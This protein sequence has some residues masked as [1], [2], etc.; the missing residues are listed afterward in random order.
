M[1]DQWYYR[2]FGHDF[3]PVDFEELKLLAQQGALSSSDEVRASQSSEWVSASSVGELN[4][5]AES[6]EGVATAVMPAPTVTTTTGAD[7][8]YY[9]FHG[10]EMGPLGFD[11]LI[12]FTEQGQLSA[13]D[14]VKLGANGKWRRV[15]SI[16]RLVAVLP[17]MAIETQIPEKKAPAPP[18]ARA[19][20][21]LSPPEPVQQP[22][23]VSAPPPAPLPANDPLTA[24]AVAAAKAAAAVAAAHVELGH[25]Q[26][27]YATADKN[28][29]GMI[30]WAMAP[31]VDPSW[32][33]WI[34]G[35]E[36]GPVAFVQIYELGVSGRLQRTDFVK[37]GMFGQYVP[38]NTVPGLFNAVEIMKQAGAALIAAKTKVA[39]ATAE[40]TRA[41]QAQALVPVP[42]SVPQ[43]APQPAPKAAVPAPEPA[44]AS[45]AVAAASKPVT[46]VA[47]PSSKPTTASS[48][49]VSIPVETPA[50]A[51]RPAPAPMSMSS[52]FAAAPAPRPMPAPAPRPV[53]SS[54]SFSISE[55]FQN[56]AAIGAGALVAVGLV[57]CAWLFMPGVGNNT[58]I[59]RYRDMKKF[60]DDV[61]VARTAKQDMSQFKARAEKLKADYVAPLK[62]EAGSAYPAKQ[63]LLWAVRDELPRMMSG[64][65]AEESKDEKAFAA[66]LKSAA[67]KLG[68]Q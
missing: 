53:R 8:W 65:L 61:R 10:Q 14:E 27:A 2:M 67:D 25:A 44:E 60:L 45:P 36:Y 17:Y 41:S 42:Q 63:N 3:G 4:L 19:P 12:A 47:T 46:P 43:P 24:L 31:N 21:V 49:S 56:P 38:A 18:P 34:G 23:P 37:N 35:V 13:D 1:A 51:P 30:Q 28:A 68:V 62:A 9:Q 66:R 50:P 20:V 29:R 6:A 59:A 54:S 7:D 11:E 16:G 15:G 64:D 58:D 5:E 52:S 32:W 22:A 55:L 57:V 40:A 48:A 33:T 39:E 26:S